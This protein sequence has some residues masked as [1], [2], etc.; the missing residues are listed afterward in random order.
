MLLRFG[1]EQNMLSACLGDEESAV[2]AEG[3]YLLNRSK[4]SIERA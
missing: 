2:E 1:R 4:Q 3:Y